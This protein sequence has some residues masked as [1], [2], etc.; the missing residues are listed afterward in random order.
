MVP[1][2]VLF[3]RRSE[4]AITVLIAVLAIPVHIAGLMVPTLY[5]DPAILIPQNLGTDLVNVALMIPLLGFSCAIMGRSAW[6]R[7]LWLGAL[8][9]LVYAYGMYALGVHW[10]RLFLAYVALFGLSFYGL[11]LGFARTPVREIAAAF[12]PRTPVRTAA[13]Y[14]T[15][16]ALLVAAVWLIDEIGATV[17]GVPPPSLAQ[18]QVP[19]NI[20][21]VFDLG[22]VLPALVIASL[23]LIRRHAWGYVLAGVL[24]VKTTAIGTWI[25]AMIAFST[26]QGFPG[27][28][29]TT[30][31][32]VLLT[33]IGIVVSW[34]FLG[35][36]ASGREPP[37]VVDP[38]RQRKEAA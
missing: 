20:V 7:L 3:T 19:T 30:L 34:R 4:I 24:L 13:L 8:G 14:L 6:A 21:H 18:L 35:A 23:L 16:V 1:A 11:V 2:A 28:I 32:F 17:R 33:L 15:T 29:E 25:V 12:P 26:M 10:N 36:L 5:R 9:Y 27:P 22:I 38:L 37:A 31:A